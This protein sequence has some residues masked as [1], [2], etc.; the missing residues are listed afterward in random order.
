MKKQV[1]FLNRVYQSA[2]D[3]IQRK[4]NEEFLEN[5]ERILELYYTPKSPLLRS[6][7]LE[8]IFIGMADAHKIKIQNESWLT[9]FE[10]VRQELD[11]LSDI[12]EDVKKGRL[13]YTVLLSLKDTNTKNNVKKIIADVWNNKIGFAWKESLLDSIYD[14]IQSNGYIDSIENKLNEIQE[15]IW[16]EKFD[17]DFNPL[18]IQIE[19]KRAFLYRLLNNRLRDKNSIF[20]FYKKNKNCH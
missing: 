3:E 10:E 6:S 9:K 16:R 14:L 8:L 18:I 1:F 4:Y 7:T 20:E 5:P 13:T 19:L 2:F 12:I 17:G 15:E 11:D